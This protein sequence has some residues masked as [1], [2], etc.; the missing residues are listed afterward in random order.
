MSAQETSAFGAL[1]RRH[2]QAAGLTQEE[3]AER[4]RLSARAVIDLERGA[5]L[6]PRRETVALL[7]E[8]LGLPPTERGAG[9]RQAR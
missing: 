4:A 9:R 8:A 7:A 1:L 2:R 5:R 3:L 6:T